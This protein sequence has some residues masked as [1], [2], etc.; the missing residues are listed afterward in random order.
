MTEPRPDR[1]RRR[2]LNPITSSNKHRTFVGRQMFCFCLSKPQAWYGIT[3]QRVWNRRRCMASPKVYFL[4]LDSIHPFEMIPFRLTTD[5][6]RSKA[7]DYI[8]GLRRDFKV[9]ILTAKHN[10]ITGACFWLMVK[11]AYSHT[12]NRIFY[13]VIWLIPLLT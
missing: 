6:I 13:A 4:R 5:S 10:K 9:V 12:A 11:S 7:S 1:A 2:D 8:H 3:R